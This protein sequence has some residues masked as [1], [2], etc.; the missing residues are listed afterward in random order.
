[1]STWAHYKAALGDTPLPAAFVDLDA[2][3]RN[4]ETLLAPLRASGKTLRIASKS[5]R[6]TALLRHLLQAGGDH[7]KGIMCFSAT[8]AAWL[9]DQG[10]DDLFVAYPTGQRS[11]ADA[12]ARANASGATAGIVVDDPAHLDLLGAAAQDHKTVIPVVV[13]VDTSYRPLGSW[14]HVGARRSPLR[15][16]DAVLSLCEDV[17][18]RPDLRLMGVM[19]YESHI[20]GAVDDSPFLS[21]AM[22]AATRAMKRRARPAVTALRSQIA[23]GLKARGIAYDLFNGGGTGS[24]SWTAAQPHLTEITAGSGFVD[25]HLFDYFAGLS[26]SPAIGFALQVVRQPDAR[27]VTCHGGGY[28]ASGAPGPDRLP[29]PWL[30]AG[31]SYVGLEGAGEVQTPLVL[32]KG[33]ALGLGDPVFF[34]HAKAGELA[35]HFNEYHFLRGPGVV[36]RVPTYRGQGQCFLG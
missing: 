24:A 3:D 33:Q 2:V 12:L 35:E 16:A 26:L 29:L 6:C 30:P 28:V 4:L 25:S 36:D 14:V 15:T 11:D 1:M 17:A 23:V 22:N 27:H 20:A 8:E 34:R 32:P 21:A 9:V 19:G 18:A 5:L 31:L 7:L 13:E 10:F